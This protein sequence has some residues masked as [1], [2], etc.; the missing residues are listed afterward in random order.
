M[1]ITDIVKCGM[2][3]KDKAKN[4]DKNNYNPECIKK[5]I[6]RYFKKEIE[7]V[8][9][10]II[11]CL[12]GNSYELIDNNRNEF[13]DELKDIIIA[14]LPHPKN[15]YIKDI[16]F[17]YDYY[18]IITYVLNK[19]GIIDDKEKNNFLKKAEFYNYA[20]IKKLSKLDPESAYENVKSGLVSVYK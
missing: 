2:C 12:G 19:A 17:R 13:K 16:H 7:Y 1:Y 5:C 6:N 20:D 11:F 4:T 8:K 18:L 3:Y 14:K 15:R 10:K 9:P